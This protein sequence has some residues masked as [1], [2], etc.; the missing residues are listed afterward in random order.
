MSAIEIDALSL[1]WLMQSMKLILNQRHLTNNISL[2]LFAKVLVKVYGWFTQE[3]SQ[4]NKQ[5]K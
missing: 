2:V 4:A 1:M 5:R 3:L